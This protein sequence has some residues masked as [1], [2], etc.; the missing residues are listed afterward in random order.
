MAET[1]TRIQMPGPLGFGGGPIG[2]MFAACDD[3]TARATLAAAWDNGIRHFD[4]AP[5]YGAGLSERRMGAFLATKPRDAYFLSTKVGRLLEPA[6]DGPELEHPFVGGLHFKRRLDYGYEAAQRGVADCLQRLG[7]GRLDVVYIHD[8]SPD[9]LGTAWTEHF[10]AAMEGAAQALTE[11]RDRGTIRGW[12]LGVNRVEPCL[13]ALDEAD[14]DVFLLATQY[15]L[16]DQ[17]GGERLLPACRER[18]IPVVVGS[19]FASGLLAGGA[20][21]NY[22]HADPEPVW[23]RDRLRHVCDRHGVDLKAA[24]AQFSA[25]H[26]AVGAILP[27]AKH[28]DRI[29]DK[30]ELM[31][32]SIPAA[33]WAELK[34]RHLL[35]GDAH[36]PG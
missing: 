7:V 13:R 17:T 11:L 16:L 5:H 10:R 34:E 27:G 25:A 19:P 36:T 31:Q 20:H 4:T 23:Q 29:R 6:P 24:A 2:D 3:A 22:Q 26:P 18:G 21:Y 14:P 32:Q 30:V 33:F 15:H 35:G 8:L 12:G 1:A 9:A 28:P